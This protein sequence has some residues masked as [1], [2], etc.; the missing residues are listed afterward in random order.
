MSDSNNNPSN[1]RN[2]T[3][4]EA[5]SCCCPQC[6]NCRRCSQSQ[7]CCG[8]VPG[9]IDPCEII[10]PPGPPG[11]TGRRGR[12]GPF[13]PPGP[14]GPASPGTIIPFASGQP[15]ALTTKNDG[16][17]GSPSYIGFGNCGTPFSDL[18]T[19]LHLEG[20]LGEAIN[21]SF[22]L[23][24]NGTLDSLT[25]FFSTVDV[26]DF[27]NTTITIKA[28][29]YESTTPDNTF[30]PIAGS[31]INLSPL[32]TGSLQNGTVCKG[33]TTSINYPVAL[34]TRLLLVFSSISTHTSQQKAFGGYASG[35]LTIK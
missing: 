1:N 11:P 30:Y 3:L 9:C 29:L 33:T 14:P 21:F 17:A 2:N 13:G 22:S 23:P 27:N 7:N 4:K 20:L 10:G 31:S 34:E 19:P 26:V 18:S 25:V 15:V 28:Q 32:L 6:C 24:R 5:K 8:N 35:G 12:R 16:T